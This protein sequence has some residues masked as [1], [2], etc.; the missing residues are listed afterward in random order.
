MSV[1]PFLSVEKWRNTEEVKT[2]SENMCDICHKPIKTKKEEEW[3]AEQ[4][5]HPGYLGRPHRKCYLKMCDKE[6]ELPWT[7]PISGETD[8]EAMKDD[9]GV[10]DGT[11]EDEYEEY[12]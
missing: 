5:N 11:E 7:D 9:L 12:Y 3:A 2:M 4:G 6:P 8:W 10:T 1:S